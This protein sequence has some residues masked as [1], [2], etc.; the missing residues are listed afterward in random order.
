[1]KLG[2]INSSTFEARQWCNLSFAV[3]I[4]SDLMNGVRAEGFNLAAARKERRRTSDMK[5]FEMQIQWLNS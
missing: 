4:P 5:P 1:M 3:T 2:I